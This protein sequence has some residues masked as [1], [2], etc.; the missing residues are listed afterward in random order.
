MENKIL[1]LRNQGKSYNQISKLLGCSKG[2]ISY[3]CGVNQ[4]EKTL[5]RTKKRRT[6]LLLHKVENFK[7]TK[8]PKETLRKFQKR[9][10]NFKKI[11]GHTNKN[12]KPTFSWFD[13][14]KKYGIDTSCYL[15]GEKINLNDHNYSLDH[16]I[17]VSKGGDNSFNNMGITTK[18]VNRMKSD[19]TPNELIKM[20][21][22]ILIYNGYKISK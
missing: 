13:V 6:N 21:K 4:K 22:K 18:L 7:Y 10:K 20:C 5:K 14:V 1:E 2:T 17:P 12:I 3:Y 15:T 19:M 9:D 8:R 11:S 16:I